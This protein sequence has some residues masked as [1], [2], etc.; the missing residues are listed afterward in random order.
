MFSEFFFFCFAHFFCGRLGER[1]VFD[2]DPGCPIPLVQGESVIASQWAA[3]LCFFPRN[4]VDAVE[5]CFYQQLIG[6]RKKMEFILKFF[7]FFFLRRRQKIWQESMVA[8]KA[9]C[10]D[11]NC[12]NCA[13]AFFA[14]TWWKDNNNDNICIQGRHYGLLVVFCFCRFTFAQLECFLVLWF[15]ANLFF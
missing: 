9:S 6:N 7:F 12:C 4:F 8:I 15:A 11:R 5:S 14:C 10:F 13:L 2:S 1:N 3:T